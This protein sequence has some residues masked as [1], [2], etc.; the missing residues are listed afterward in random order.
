MPSKAFVAR[1]QFDER[2][3]PDATR[4]LAS[5]A[6]GEGV[7]YYSGLTPREMARPS[8]FRPAWEAYKSGRAVL[9]QR[10]IGEQ[11]GKNADGAKVVF[12]VFDYI[13]IGR[14]RR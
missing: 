12:G 10:R 11:V 13:A 5:I 1:A 14:K 4:A 7:V 6:P 9:V 2:V 8:T 3:H